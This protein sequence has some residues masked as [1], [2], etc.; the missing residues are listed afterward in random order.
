ME[1]NGPV[2]SAKA[3]KWVSRIIA[4]KIHCAATLNIT[5]TVGM[6]EDVNDALLLFGIHCLV[7][8]E[9]KNTA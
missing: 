9:S 3:F 7:I 2:R 1:I 6:I 4:A 8:K 5:K